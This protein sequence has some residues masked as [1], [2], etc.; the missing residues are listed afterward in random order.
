ML[1][2]LSNAPRPQSGSPRPDANPAGRR[3]TTERTGPRV[4]DGRGHDTSLDRRGRTRRATTRPPR[5]GALVAHRS[6]TNRRA[7]R[8][9]R[10]LPR[11]ASRGYRRR[12]KHVGSGTVDPALSRRSRCLRLSQGSVRKSDSN[13]HR[14]DGNGCRCRQHRQARHIM[15]IRTLGK[16]ADL[17]GRPT[18]HNPG[19]RRR[20]RSRRPGRHRRRRVL[21]LR[22]VRRR[23][24]H[25][26]GRATAI[27]SI[28]HM[29]RGG[30]MNDERRSGG[31][32][33]SAVSAAAL[34]SY[35]EYGSVKLRLPVICHRA[36]KRPPDSGA[37]KNGF[38]QEV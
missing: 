18:G 29:H 20:D 37:H 1:A 8:S 35:P 27:P 23:G 22:R 28:M 25:R 2:S 14:R 4:R 38:A 16:D 17:D 11:R 5:R 31:S 10:R 6:T 24:H 36:G 7:R 26:P 30:S 15:V 34:I 19:P 9:H 12:S 3:S 33:R 32:R 13:Q 21:L